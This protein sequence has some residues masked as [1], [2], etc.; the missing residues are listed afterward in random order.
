[1]AV[2]KGHRRE[3]LNWFFAGELRPPGAQPEERFID[4]C[5]KCNRCVTACP[6]GSI[7]PAGWKYG[8]AVGTPVIEPRDVPCYL[9]M[10]CPGVCPTG[11]LV[12]VEKGEVDMGTAVIDESLCY[13]FRG[14]LCRACVDACPF[15]GSAI[16]MTLA[17]L[18]V[19]HGSRC[20]GCGL[21][22][23]ACPADEEAIRVARAE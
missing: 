20:V 19:V 23:R 11:A 18:P 6:Y 22:Q 10:I 13:P 8:L 5:I 4:L 7:R 16:S 21:C 3:F 15:P 12:P 1:M 14:V 2:R 9:C 17:L